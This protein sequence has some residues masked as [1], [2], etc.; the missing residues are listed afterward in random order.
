MYIYI[1]LLK[2]PEE[3]KNWITCFRK[4]LMQTNQ[5][6]CSVIDVLS[7]RRLEQYIAIKEET[8]R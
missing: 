7:E 2:V 1:E 6:D 5:K 3:T 8:V 4:L